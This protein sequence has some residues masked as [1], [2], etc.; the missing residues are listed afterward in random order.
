M[1]RS[2]RPCVAPPRQGFGSAGPSAWNTHGSAGGEGQVREA[3]TGYI[4][5]YHPSDQTQCC[6]DPGTCL[7]G[8]ESRTTPVCHWLR[9][10][11][12]A[13]NPHTS[14]S[15]PQEWQTWP[16]GTT[17]SPWTNKCHPGRREPVGWYALTRTGHRDMSPPFISKA[18]RVSVPLSSLM[19]ISSPDHFLDIFGPHPTLPTGT[20]PSLSWSGGTRQDSLFPGPHPVPR[21]PPSL[22]AS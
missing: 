5:S 15:L 9:L 21:P 10:C 20:R 8:S 16:T 7:T 11:P 13:V 3:S 4:T 12:G 18:E 1:H 14:A 22:S 2:P 17:R 6:W 19:V